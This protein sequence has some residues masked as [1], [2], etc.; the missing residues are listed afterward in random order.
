MYCEH[1]IMYRHVSVMPEE[2]VA[3]LNCKPGKII[4][5]CTLGGAGHSAR[6]L[7]KILPDGMLIAIDQDMA[8]IENANIVFKDRVSRI[9][10][11]HGNFD[12]LE[13]YLGSC[14]LSCVDGIL[15]DVG[16]SLYQLEASGRGFSFSRNEPLDMRMNA[17]SDTMTAEELVNTASEDELAK[18]FREYGEERYAGRIAMMIVRT[19]IR[20]KIVSSMQLANIIRDVVPKKSVSRIHPATRVFMA[21]RIAVNRE[22][23]RLDALIDNAPKLL[24]PGGRLCVISFHSLE[25]RIVK[26][27]LRAYEKG[28]VCPVKFPKCVCGGQKTMKILTPKALTPSEVEIAVNPMARSA[29]LRAAEKL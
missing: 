4:A 2:A 24:A 22:L 6:I 23:E 18:I 13:E 21:L 15:A 5:D 28:C 26:H 20:E 10:L 11:F 17:E 16:L 14:G 29:K 27:R 19:R 25:D 12:H 1:K 8:A 7:E 3:F 9:R